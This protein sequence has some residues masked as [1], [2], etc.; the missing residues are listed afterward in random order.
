MSNPTKKK[1]RTVEQ[2]QS[3]LHKEINAAI[4]KLPPKPMTANEVVKNNIII[5]RQALDKGLTMTTVGELIKSAFGVAVS[6]RAIKR[7]LDEVGSNPAPPVHASPHVE[8][9]K[10][11]RVDGYDFGEHGGDGS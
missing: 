10:A 3:K 4:D 9:S 5:V 7:V 1:P 11:R 2:M 6:A 8:F